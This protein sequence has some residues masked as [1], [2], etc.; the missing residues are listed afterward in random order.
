MSSPLIKLTDVGVCY[1]AR[2]LLSGAYENWALK[3]VN[4]SLNKGDT[5]GVIGRN[6]VGKSTLLKILADIIQP[7]KGVIERQ[8][9]SSTILSLGVGFLNHLDARENA[10]MAGML[11]GFSRKEIEPKIQGILEFA[12]LTAY[13]KVPIGTYST[14]MVARLGFSI[15]MEVEPDILLIDEMLAVG[16]ADFRQKSSK[17]IRQRMGSEQTVVLVAHNEH[18]I[19]EFCNQVVWIEDGKT[20]AS[21]T[22]DDMLEQYTKFLVERRRAAAR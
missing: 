22:A 5:L 21:G 6:G 9:C 12:E 17:A 7:D 19:R 14:G 11:L 8:P 1:K 15:A 4:L 10:V 18:V 16:D 2:S 20:I 13:D 3:Q